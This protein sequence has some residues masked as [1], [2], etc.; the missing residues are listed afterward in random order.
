MQNLVE[1][2]YVDARL[3]IYAI[4]GGMSSLLVCQSWGIRPAQHSRTV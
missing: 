4:L 2:I 1:F 3:K